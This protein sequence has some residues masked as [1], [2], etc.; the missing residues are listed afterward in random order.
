MQCSFSGQKIPGD[1]LFVLYYPPSMAHQNWS[2][3]VYAA[4]RG[5]E[6][7]AATLAELRNFYSRYVVGKGFYS[8]LAIGL[9][10]V[11]LLAY[12]FYVA[13]TGWDDANFVSAFV[14]PFAGLM[15]LLFSRGRYR[16]Y[17]ERKSVWDETGRDATA[18]EISAI[19]EEKSKIAEDPSAE[20]AAPILRRECPEA[21]S[22]IAFQGQNFRAFTYLDFILFPKLKNPAS[23]EELPAQHSLHRDAYYVGDI[24]FDSW[25]TFQRD[26]RD[27]VDPRFV[28]SGGRRGVI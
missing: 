15:L 13:A 25:R 1:K 16:S 2:Q 3:S 6:A 17:A 10:G 4:A 28:G 7:I 24:V 23:K 21:L 8:N 18:A 11:A 26:R 14:A 27:I 9:V 20:T 22:E 12:W 5:R 19:E